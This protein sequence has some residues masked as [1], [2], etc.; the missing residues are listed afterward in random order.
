MRFI[1]V[2]AYL[3]A[4][5]RYYPDC[6]NETSDNP[7]TLWK[8][9]SNILHRTQSLSIPAFS[10]KKSL[11]ESFSNFFSKIEKIGMNFFNDI[12][13]ARVASRMFCFKLATADEVRKLIINSPT[14]ACD[15]DPIPTELL[16]SCLNVL[17]VPITQMVNL[18]LSSG[19]FLDIF[20]TSHVM[21]LLKKPSLSKHEKLQTS[22]KPKLCIEN[23]R[24]NYRIEFAHILKET[25]Y[26]I[27]IS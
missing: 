16:E 6:I 18:S 5:R 8:T 20:K 10:D 21:P 1:L 26:Q 11:S 25:I 13:S 15:L 3:D 9:I 22:V 2:S 24:T 7:R 23:H 19:V 12:K 27:S 4:R 17:L 14:K